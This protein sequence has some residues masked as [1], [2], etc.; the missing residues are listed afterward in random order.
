MPTVTEHFPSHAAFLDAIAAS[1]TKALANRMDSLDP[2]THFAGRPLPDM[3]DACRTMTPFQ[4]LVQTVDDLAADLVATLPPL[5]TIKRVRQHAAQGSR[6]NIHRVLRSDLAHAWTRTQRS[7]IPG[8]GG[9]M[10][11][12]L[13]Q[14]YPSSTSHASIRWSTAASL[15]L[16]QLCEQSGRRVA[17]VAAIQGTRSFQDADACTSF[18]L[19]DYAHP[20]NLQEVVCTMDRAWLRRLWCRWCE[21]QSPHHQVQSGYGHPVSQPQSYL[22]LATIHDWPAPLVGCRPSFDHVDSQATALAWLTRQLT[23]LEAA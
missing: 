21:M 15:A 19:K 13:I 2:D 1:G 7:P 16:A 23:T 3:L 17:L 6:V 8:H 10:T 9:L 18:T 5:P 11:L 22:D 20:W 12:L 4:S 14:S